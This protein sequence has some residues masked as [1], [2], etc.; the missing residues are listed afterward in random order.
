MQLET[1]DNTKRIAVIGRTGSGKTVFGIFLLGEMLKG[2]WRGMPGTIFDFKRDKLIQKLIDNGYAKVISIR[3]KPPTKP[4]LYVVR[5]LPDVDNDAVTEYLMKVWFLE[6]HFIYIDEG[7]MI[8]RYNKSF[9]A[10][11]TQGRS[12]HIPMIY[13]SQRPVMMDLFAFSEADYFA[14]FVLTDDKDKVRVK[15]YTGVK[16]NRDIA[17]YHCVWYDVGNDD[18]ATFSPCPGQAEILA[19]F[20]QLY[21]PKGKRAI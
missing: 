19:T 7:Y 6:D 4:G 16:I 8:G 15:E 13:L 10:L 14:I 9:R 21:A 3:D 18:M 20:D 17:K 12:K 5:P 11:L 1:P 2:P